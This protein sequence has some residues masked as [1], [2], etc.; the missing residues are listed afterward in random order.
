MQ[1]YW[2]LPKQTNAHRH[3]RVVRETKAISNVNELISQSP[4]GESEQIDCANLSHYRCHTSLRNEEIEMSEYDRAYFR[5][6][7]VNW[8]NSCSQW[9]LSL[10]LPQ[11]PI[12]SIPANWSSVICTV[13]T[14][15]PHCG[16]IQAFRLRAEILNH[17]GATFR[18]ANVNIERSCRCWGRCEAHSCKQL[19]KCQIN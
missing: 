8:R 16:L 12:I 5:H 10:A 4:M 3:R 9:Q 6:P 13:Y 2:L 17:M 18:C 19:P 14:Q 1:F 11:W 15:R 7:L